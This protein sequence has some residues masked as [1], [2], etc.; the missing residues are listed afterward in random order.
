MNIPREKCK[1]II[2]PRGGLN[3]G[4]TRAP[5]LTAVNCTAVGI[6]KAETMKDTVCA[7]GAQNIIVLSIPDKQRAWRYTT[8]RSL[9]LG[10]QANETY[11]YFPAPHDTSK[12]V[13][14]E[15]PKTETTTDI[16]GNITHPRR[17]KAID[18]Q[19]IGGTTMS[20]VL[21][22]GQEV[23][24]TME[25]GPTVVRRRR[26]RQHHQVCRMISE[27]RTGKTYARNKTQRFASPAAS[28]TLET[29]TAGNASH[30]ASFVTA[31]TK[32]GRRAG[33]TISSG[34]IQ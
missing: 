4:R 25:H 29:R 17:L 5:T 9:I 12:G 24:S 6:K 30:V 27:I 22:Q 1:I 21:F 14:Y 10:E 33:A 2:K 23:P 28:L 3:T 7:N 8:I 19:R 32:P 18:A 31:S 11:A 34:H 13:I 15:I 26:Y 20:L 16:R